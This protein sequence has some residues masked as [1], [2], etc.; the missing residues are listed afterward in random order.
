MPQRSSAE[1]LRDMV[2]SARLAI[3][4]LAGLTEEQYYWDVKS[5]DAASW[6]LIVI[7]EA[8]AQ[9]LKIEGEQN[10]PKIAWPQIR[11]MRNRLVHEYDNV[12]LDVVWD[13]IQVDLAPMVSAIE[14]FLAQRS[15]GDT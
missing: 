8:A 6:R 10:L 1:Y 2:H 12:R 3:D 7:G 5:Q 15:E 9:S 4:H 14:S 11:G 13:T